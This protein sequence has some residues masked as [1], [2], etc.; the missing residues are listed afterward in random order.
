[1]PAFRTIFQ[2]EL[3]QCPLPPTPTRSSC[4]L[5][6]C[7]SV[8]FPQPQP[9]QVVPYSSVAAF[10][11]PN[12]NQ[13]KL[14]L[15]HL[16]QRALPPTPTR[17]SCPLLTCCSVPFP[18]PDQVVPCSP[19]AVP[20]SPNPNQIK[21]S[22]THLLQRAFPPTPTRSSC[23]LLT[24]C[25][26][27]F[28]QP[29][30]DQVVPYS[31]VAASPSP[32][33]SSCPLLSCCSAPFPQPD[34]VVPYSPV[35]VPPPP[36]PNQIK[37][38][39]TNLLQCPLPPTPTRSSCPLL[40]CCSVPF[41]QPDQVVPYSPVAAFPS[42]TRSSCLYSPVWMGP[43]PAGKCVGGKSTVNNCK[44]CPWRKISM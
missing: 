32:T 34:Q 25:S 1:M 22:L 33:R 27:P 42:P 40:T 4:P 23:P 24:C 12:P 8:P 41:P 14:S 21:L 13:I 7:F 16:L 15:T 44:V 17:S 9:D 11:S 39:L 38:S 18:Q 26:V 3:L 5:L 10:P 20:P 37:L 28:P 19:V 30:P 29:Q 43:L 31:P 2:Q 35:A 36:N 6:T